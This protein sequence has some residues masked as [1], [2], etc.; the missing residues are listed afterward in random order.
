MGG[1]KRTEEGLSEEGSRG[2]RE[3]GWEGNFKGGIL[4]RAL[5]RCIRG[6]P[7]EAG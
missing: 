1:R 4:M 7:G 2:A 5:A 6:N 3:Q